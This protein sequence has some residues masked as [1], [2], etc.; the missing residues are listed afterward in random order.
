MTTR[1]RQAGLSLFLL[2]IVQ[3][4]VF[5]EATEWTSRVI[6]STE[7]ALG[8]AAIGDVDPDSPGNEVVAVSA[9][10]NVW[11]AKWRGEG[12]SAKSVKAADGEL[13]MCAIGD[14][15]PDSAGN[16]LVAV[17]MVEGPESTT[18][19]GQV[20]LVRRESGAWR[21]RTIFT[22]SHMI[23]G[24]AIG[25]VCSKHE[26]NEIIAAGFNHRVTL[27]CRTEQGAW[28]PETIYV[29]NDRLKLVQVGDVLPQ[30][31]GLEVLVCGSD[32]SVVVLWQHTLGWRHEIMY[33]GAAGQSRIAIGDGCVLVGG[34]DG[35]VTLVKR[36]ESGFVADVLGREPG[37]IRG[38]GIGDV[39]PG[40]AGVEY[41]ATGYSRNV[42]QYVPMEDGYWSSR[43][44]FTAEKTLHHMVLGDVNPKRPGLELV[45]CGHGGKLIALW[46]K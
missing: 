12:W 33:R 35:K 29:A 39:D 22:D 18:G 23:H 3:G 14:V 16:E 41:Y 37:K 5:G 10:G 32:G 13:I 46:P 20:V 15:E 30:R 36:T 8:G 34:D 40:A 2:G 28:Q 21:A 1:A 4:A 27:L 43:V 44:I 9:T 24:V 11:I 6:L 25:D 17:G 19:P 38:V 31:E 45:T 7:E 26:G 42:V